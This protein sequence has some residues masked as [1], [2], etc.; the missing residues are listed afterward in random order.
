MPESKRVLVVDDEAA[1]REVMAQALTLEGYEVL[2]ATDGAEALEQVRRGRPDAVVLDLMMP[3]MSGW[4]FMEACRQERLCDGT[5]VLV[6][7]AYRGLVETT[8]ALGASACIAK[9]FDLTVF[10]GA[11][12]RLVQQAA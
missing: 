2:M 8:P 5:P 4:E 3:R 7:S 1:I 12:E 6:V 9:P 11:V 10:L